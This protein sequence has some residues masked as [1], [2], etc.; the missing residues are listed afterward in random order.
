MDSITQMH[1]S[2]KK[3]K[4]LSDE[5]LSALWDEYI[6]D[7]SNRKV[8]DIL[9]VQY[10]Y[11]IKYVVGRLRVSL[12]DTIASE[13]I[14]SFGIEGL[15]RAIEKF[16]KDKNARFETYALTKI[17][18]TIID[19]IREQDWIPRALR[20]KQKEIAAIIQIM[21][22][23][24]GRMP[25]EAEIAS[26]ANI[27]IEKVQ[28]IMKMAN[29]MSVVSLN[30]TKDRQEQSV[31]IIDTIED[32]KHGTPL[33][34]LEEKDSKKD[35]IKGLARLPERERLLLTLYYHENMTFGEI[36][37]V[38]KISE[39]RCCQLHAQAIMKLRNILTSN[40]LELRKIVEWVIQ[41]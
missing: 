41:I 33:E 5:E 29:A 35:L 24:L 21:Q 25:T 3:L 12:P 37:A 10:I 34:Q 27:P 32:E 28:E 7:R 26:R 17:R 16:S 8:K 13:D 15:I 14:S 6:A 39:S 20:K 31:E 4:R 9:V 22:K 1:L 18:G 19:R 40:R 23:E 30:S 36:G 38:L 11:L 2:Q